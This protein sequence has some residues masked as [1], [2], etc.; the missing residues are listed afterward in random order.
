MVAE[1]VARNA[2]G[3]KDSVLLTWEGK[4][5]LLRI[6]VSKAISLISRAAGTVIVVGWGVDA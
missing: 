3:N 2:G 4:S 6:G 5:E 1:G